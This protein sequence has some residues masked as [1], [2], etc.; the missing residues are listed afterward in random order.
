MLER[1]A[2]ILDDQEISYRSYLCQ[3]LYGSFKVKTLTM[4]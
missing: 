2:W 3:N 4:C 1:V